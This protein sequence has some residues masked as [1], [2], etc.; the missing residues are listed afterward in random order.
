MAIHGRDD[1][2][3]SNSTV[4]VHEIDKKWHAAWHK[5]VLPMFKNDVER[6]ERFKLIWK[7]FLCL[8][9]WDSKTDNFEN[10]YQMLYSWAVTNGNRRLFGI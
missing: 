2:T 7:Y 9:S 3:V 1:F 6:M 8:Y 10:G 4:I 5:M